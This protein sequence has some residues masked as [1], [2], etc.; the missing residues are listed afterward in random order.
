M[1]R[2][3]IWKS[4]LEANKTRKEGR[5]ISRGIA[6]K[7]LK[8]KDISKAAHELKLNPQMENKKHPR[9]V[10]GRVLVDKKYPKIK[11]LKLIADEIRKIRKERSPDSH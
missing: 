7:D 10:D 6:V 5:K 4:N 8:L 2:M 3:V 11:T 1:K 9:G